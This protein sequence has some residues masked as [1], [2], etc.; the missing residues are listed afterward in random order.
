MC[1]YKEA[2]KKRTREEQNSHLTGEIKNCFS[3][4]DFMNKL[5]T[6]ANNIEFKENL[7][8]PYEFKGIPWIRDM[9]WVQKGCMAQEMVWNSKIGLYRL[10]APCL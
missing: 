10:R 8:N 4:L 9:I 5:W 3:S 6:C 1:V 2:Y 7:G